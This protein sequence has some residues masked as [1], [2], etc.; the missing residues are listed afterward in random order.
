VKGKRLLRATAAVAIRRKTAGARALTRT[1]LLCSDWIVVTLYLLVRCRAVL[2]YPLSLGHGL[3]PDGV[4]NAL[5][6]Y[7]GI[8]GR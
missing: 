2:F 6:V 4:V 3:I 5:I 8:D 7:M 1:L